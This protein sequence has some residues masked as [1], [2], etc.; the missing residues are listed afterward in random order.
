MSNAWEVEGLEPEG[1]GVGW[2][3]WGA[4]QVQAEP[5]RLAILKS[6]PQPSSWQGSPEKFK[7]WKLMLQNN[8]TLALPSLPDV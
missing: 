6:L 3:E 5:G 4:Q 7:D 1:G 2:A 8:L